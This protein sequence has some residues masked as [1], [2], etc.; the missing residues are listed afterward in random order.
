MYDLR[1]IK[2]RPLKGGLK[3]LSRA[4][5]TMRAGFAWRSLTPTAATV[6]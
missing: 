4:E 6:V 3:N 1:A 5:K 2:G